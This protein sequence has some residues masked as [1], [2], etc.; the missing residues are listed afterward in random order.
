LTSKASSTSSTNTIW[1]LLSY[2]ELRMSFSTSAR[3]VLERRK[4]TCLVWRIWRV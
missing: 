2:N 1:T 4:M 3:R